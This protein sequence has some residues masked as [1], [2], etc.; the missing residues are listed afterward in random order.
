MFRRLQSQFKRSVQRAQWVHYRSI[1]EEIDPCRLFAPHF[2]WSR[3]RSSNRLKLYSIVD[4][5]GYKTMDYA[6]TIEE[7]LRYRFPV[8]NEE[9]TRPLQIETGGFMHE[10][11]DEDPEFTLRKLREFSCL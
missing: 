2:D 10:L 6:S 3:G 8:D 11:G 5:S 7:L 1:L 9:N 4:R